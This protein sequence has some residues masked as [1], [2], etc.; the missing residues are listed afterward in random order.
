[1]LSFCIAFLF[2][3]VTKA[4]AETSSEGFGPLPTRNYSPVQDMFLGMP[5][6]GPSTIRRGTTQVRLQSAQSNTVSNQHNTD[7]SS[8][9]KME[10]NRTSFD[11]RHGISDKLEMGL[12]VPVLYRSKGFLEPFIEFME[13]TPVVG[14]DGPVRNTLTNVPFAYHVQRNG[15][16]LVS[17][18]E[19]QTGLGDISIYAKKEVA[20]EGEWLPKTSLRVAMKLPTGS[21]G[22]AFGSGTFD[23]GIGV[24]G[25]KNPFPWWIMYVD[26]SGIFPTQKFEGV[27][28][29][30]AFSGT[31]ANEFLLSK[32]FS[33]GMQLNSYTSKFLSEFGTTTGLSILDKGVNELAGGFTYAFRNGARIQLF[34][35]EGLDI[36]KPAYSGGEADLTVSLALT[37]LFGSRD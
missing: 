10:Q 31:F 25:K 24:T 37:Y 16:T 22:N 11:V 30:P 18:S 6:E 34:A 5:P 23:F 17:G 8:M 7:A 14:T 2:L 32:N 20:E 21:R 12:E 35:V 26:V 13:K 33:I 15:K 9:I 19:G 1:M 36:P 3:A 27:K 28:T 4:C 29:I